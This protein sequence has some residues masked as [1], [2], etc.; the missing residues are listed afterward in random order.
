VDLKPTLELLDPHAVVH[1]LVGEV[2]GERVVE[3]EPRV[4]RRDVLARGDGALALLEDALG[5]LVVGG[6]A[7]LVEGADVLVIVHPPSLV[8][9]IKVS[10]R[11]AN[12]VVVGS[13]R[14]RCFNAKT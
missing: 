10:D 3:L 1:F 9:S 11:R 4:R 12:N 13:E 7:L 2:V 6:A 5:L 8:P 14:T